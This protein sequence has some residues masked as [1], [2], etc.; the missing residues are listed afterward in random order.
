M[1]RL[2]VKSNARLAYKLGVEDS[3]II[4][5]PLLKVRRSSSEVWEH[6]FGNFKTLMDYERG[7]LKLLAE[8]YDRGL[9]KGKQ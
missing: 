9:Q 2:L 4:G 1:K 5:T 6:V 3:V 8:Y 7:S